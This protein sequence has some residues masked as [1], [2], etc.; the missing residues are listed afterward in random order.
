MSISS[1][2]TAVVI[3]LDYLTLPYDMCRMLW[4]L[5]ERAMLE[6]GFVLDGRNFVSQNDPSAVQ[7]AR[8]VMKS[9]EPTFESLGYSQFEAVR[10]FY[11]FDLAS[12][13]DL[14]MVDAAE[15]VELIE[16]PN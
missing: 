6:A 5:V 2:R 16:L 4:V 15:V 9:L 13:V 1:S 10:E 14:H 11:C 7:R 12:R 8:G 3:N